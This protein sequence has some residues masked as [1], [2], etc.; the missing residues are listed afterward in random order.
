MG[1]SRPDVSFKPAMRKFNKYILIYVIAV[2][3][4]LIFS[5]I[6]DYNSLFRSQYEPVALNFLDGNGFT[7]QGHP[8]ILYPPGYS[9]FIALLYK[10]FWKSEI[11]VKTVQILVTSFTPIIMSLVHY[12][13]WQR[14]K[15]AMLCGL[16]VAIMPITAVHDSLL[17]AGA[18]SSFFLVLSVLALSRGDDKYNYLLFFPAGVFIG[19]GAQFRSE[20]AGLMF[21]IPLFLLVTRLNKKIHKAALLF[22]GAVVIII[23]WT[24]R[25][26]VVFGKLSLTPPGLGLATS[27]VIGK[28][29]NQSGLPYGDGEI[30][31]AEGHPEIMW[32]HPY[33]RDKARL[34]NTINYA[35]SKPWKYFC[36]VLGNTPISW[37]GH[38]MY[39]ASTDAGFQKYVLTS[40][41]KFVAIRTFAGEHPLAIADRLAGISISVFVFICGFLGIITTKNEDYRVWIII[42]VVCYYLAVAPFIGV[43]SRYSIPVYIFIVPFAVN[44]LQST[45]TRKTETAGE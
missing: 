9:I 26:Y 40:R 13:I 1:F 6:T 5:F 39:L 30:C 10:I 15:S 11:L 44:F 24:I 31:K 20:I 35:L 14:E 22:A 43:L 21:W 8:F 2:I 38:S 27:S 7:L 18:L 12:N 42:E 3:V 29:D 41:D 28:L 37:F 17:I 33:E 34:Q 25:N 36:I 4:R 45:R 23:P 16:L 32:P 19:I